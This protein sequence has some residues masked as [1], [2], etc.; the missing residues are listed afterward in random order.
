VIAFD[1]VDPLGWVVLAIVDEEAM[2]ADSGP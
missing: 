2:R 1:R